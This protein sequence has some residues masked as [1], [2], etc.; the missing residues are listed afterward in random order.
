MRPSIRGRATIGLA[1]I[2]VLTLTAAVAAAQS[3]SK[4]QKKAPEPPPRGTPVLWREPTDIASR[5]LF[6][7]P[8]GG[9][10]R[11][12]LS[13][14]TFIEEE[15]GGYSTKYRVRDGS[16][17]VWV[18][19]VGKESQSETAAVRLLWAIGYFTEI[20]YLAPR[21]DIPGKGTFENVR[22]EAR[23]E[24]V[25]RLDEWKWKDNPFVWTK[26]LQG[27]VV[28]MALFNNWDIKDTNNK[29][30]QLRSEHDGRYELRYVISDLG[31]SFGKVKSDIPGFWR[32][33]R[34]RNEPK[35]FLDSAFVEDVKE[36]RVH[37]HYKGKSQELF[38]DIK[39]EEAKWVGGLL[40][41]LS[42]QQLRDAFRAANYTPDEVESLTE[43]VRARINELVALPN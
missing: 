35:D 9:A 6:L 3:K 37:F 4:D 8:G 42:D 24:Y 31:A 39:V 32:I 17:R 14:L 18:A 33:A 25:K 41:R 29:I 36:G 2:I 26:E 15:K 13:K 22:F 21:A 38:D 20:N 1:I 27:L 16:G 12:D 7:G 40:A 10:M 34:S 23:P 28:M 5:D 30:L 19:K 43:A 11:P